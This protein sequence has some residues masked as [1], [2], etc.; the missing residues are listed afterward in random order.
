MALQPGQI[1]KT[2][3][4]DLVSDFTA[5]NAAIA[6]KA[7]Q[8]ALQA[9]LD[10]EDNPHN[11][12]IEQL[13]GVSLDDVGVANG[14]ASLDSS[15]KIPAAQIPAMALE[16]LVVVANETERFALTIDDVQEG[17]LVKQVDSLQT[18]VVTDTDELDN[19]VGYT[20]VAQPTVAPVDSVFGRIGAV[21]AE[22]G[23]YDSDLITNESSVDGATVT[24]ALDALQDAITAAV[25]SYVYLDLVPAGTVN[26]LN[27]D[28][29][30]KVAGVTVAAIPEETEVLL[31]NLWQ[32]PGPLPDGQYT[33]ESGNTI[34]R[35][36]VAPVSP[37]RVRMRGKKA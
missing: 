3:V 34:A 2:Q 27:T 18:F 30:A 26:G 9:H 35:F 11:V 14:V 23:D 32:E 4:E 17:D 19:L 25:P 12:T 13:N 8:T 16:R 31:N 5:V 21:V 37:Y 10:D 20:V 15:G 7:N 6:L 22:A 33:W 28:F 29:T 1:A 24:E 36:H